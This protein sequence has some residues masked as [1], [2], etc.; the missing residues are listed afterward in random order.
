MA[1]WF[2]ASRHSRTGRP[3]S[4]VILRNASQISLQAAS[5]LGKRPRVLMILRNHP[6][7]LS[8][9]FVV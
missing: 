3:Q 6:F 1:N 9:A 4:D 8:I 5:S 2:I 7:T